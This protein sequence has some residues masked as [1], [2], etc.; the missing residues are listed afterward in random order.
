[1]PPKK[2]TRQ[3]TLPK[4]RARPAK[5]LEKPT[6]TVHSQPFQL[7]KPAW[8]SV[9]VSLKF[10]TSLF[11]FLFCWW[12]LGVRYRDFLYVS[13][14]SDI[15][16]YEFDYF[17]SAFNE[18]GGF[19]CY[20]TSFFIQ[21]FDKPLLGGLI[22]A[23]FLSVIQLLTARCFLLTR[24][25]WLL[26]FIPPLLMT[27]GVIWTRYYIF[28]VLEIN[29]LFNIFPGIFISLLLPLIYNRG[30]TF[31]TRIL[32]I[33]ILLAVLFPL[34]GAYSLLGALFCL[35]FEARRCK[36]G[37]VKTNLEFIGLIILG[38]P[39]LWYFVYRNTTMFSMFYVSA[40]LPRQV[41]NHDYIQTLYPY[42]LILTILYIYYAGL[43]V[44]T[45]VRSNN[46][47]TKSVSNRD[48]IS[49]DHQ[50]EPIESRSDTESTSNFVNEAMAE[51]GAKTVR[52]EK[53]ELSGTVVTP[54]K[55][56]APKTSN[57]DR[58]AASVFLLMLLLTFF[59]TY[60]ADSFFATLA[61]QQVLDN[62]DWDR[63]MA[64]DLH[65]IEP[66]RP[67]IMVRNLALFEKGLFADQV[68]Q[69]AQVGRVFPV[70]VSVSTYRIYG[71]IVLYR[72]GLTNFAARNITN[73]LVSIP[74]S[75]GTSKLF[76]RISLVQKRYEI[77]RRFIERLEKTRT[78]RLWVRKYRD[79][80]DHHDEKAGVF[81]ARKLPIDPA[82]VE[83]VQKEIDLIESRAPANNYFTDVKLP[84]FG[85]MELGQH[86][87]FENMTYQ[88]QELTLLGSMLTCSQSS[89][90]KN[91]GKFVEVLG[92][93]PMPR[94]IQEGYLYYSFMETR[95]IGPPLYK[96][97]PTI[98]ARFQRYMD[99]TSRQQASQNNL[100]LVRQKSEFAD[101]FWWYVNDQPETY[102]Y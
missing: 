55:E 25:S 18:I 71:D 87:G 11:F 54:Q 4:N 83:A 52:P 64:I 15:F 88:M 57:G 43:I 28:N 34:I 6:K 66:V 44:F 60:R 39:L 17:W 53:N 23:V 10:W 9:S 31:Q 8:N 63:A 14:N 61:L 21:F 99:I 24:F 82:N 76:V 94:Y 96:W 16:L 95:K 1:M 49:T 85:V 70:L 5:K 69:W 97:D 33:V 30:N 93:R 102:Y 79:W 26:S 65:C 2:S 50:P 73:K 100:I 75:A 46:L 68:F 47:K 56:N 74:A 35:A 42:P 101:T 62:E 45:I 41:Y 48:T 58:F 98:L 27:S 86:D 84:E 22:L 29:A 92:E 7:W 38:L 36:P 89:F 51:S 81:V 78:H 32:I 90:M 13:Q 19:L 72:Y 3:T 67:T 40:L 37:K 59:Y 80:L 12:F 77:A 20:T 91:I